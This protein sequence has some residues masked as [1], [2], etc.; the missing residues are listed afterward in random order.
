MDST[1]AMVQRF[2]VPVPNCDPF[3]SSCAMIHEDGQALLVV[4]LQNAWADFCHRLIKISTS[5]GTLCADRVAQSVAADMG[6]IYPV[7]HKPEFVV[8]VAKHLALS[9]VDRIDLHLGA[10]SSSAHVTHVRNYIIHPGKRTESKFHE[11][12]A[13]E[14]LPDADVRTLLNVRF[15]GGA[16]LFERWVRDLQRTAAG[17]TA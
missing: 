9:N 11:V 13:Y 1:N 12:S 6:L 4:K 15:P 14:G 16:T 7:W 8:R 5:K 10:N 2:D 3:N 17:S